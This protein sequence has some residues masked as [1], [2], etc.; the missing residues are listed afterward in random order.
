MDRRPAIGDMVP[1]PNVLTMEGASVPLSA[2]RGPALTV[3]EFIRHL[4]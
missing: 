2:F 4:G 1:D 3:Y